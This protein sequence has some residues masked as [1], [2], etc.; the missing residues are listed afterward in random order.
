MSDSK[1]IMKNEIILYMK[2]YFNIH[3]KSPKIEEDHPFTYNQI[4]Q[5][6]QTW[7]DAL[8]AADLPLNRNKVVYTSCKQC[9][10][11]MTKQFKE[12]KKSFYDFCSHSCAAI[13]NN[14]G[15]KMSWQTKE[16][17][18]N[19]LIK[20]KFTKCVI[21]GVRFSYRKRKRQSCGDKCLS[22]LKTRNN[23]IKKG[24]IMAFE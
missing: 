7:N 11:P 2:N 17:I 8:I 24:L 4:K 10:K 21:C 16:K 15:R 22:D 13:F 23:K 20:I 14:T 12:I 6:F 1:E 3:N 19:K 9:E 18:R 5:L